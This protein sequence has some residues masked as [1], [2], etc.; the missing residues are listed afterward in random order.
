MSNR[1]RVNSHEVEAF[2]IANVLPLVM[3]SAMLSPDA[4]IVLVLENETRHKWLSE[5]DGAMPSVGDFFVRDSA[6]NVTY[7]VDA[8]K[9]TKLFRG[10]KP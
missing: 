7:I 9:F 3:N 10:P 1:Y 4:G 8:T 2:K 6:L 5:K